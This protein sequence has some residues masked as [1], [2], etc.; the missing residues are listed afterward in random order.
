LKATYTLHKMADVM[1]IRRLLSLFLT[2]TLFGAVVV[3]CFA[4]IIIRM[5]QR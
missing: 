3:A 1:M 5:V 2:L 4:A